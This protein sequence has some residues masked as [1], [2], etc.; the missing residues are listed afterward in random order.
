MPEKYR[1]VKKGSKTD[2]VIIYYEVTSCLLSSSGKIRLSPVKGTNSLFISLL[3]QFLACHAMGQLL[4]STGDVSFILAMDLFS[5]LE[6]VV[7]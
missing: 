4:V 5:Y 1:Y 3:F 7:K 6:E 2:Y